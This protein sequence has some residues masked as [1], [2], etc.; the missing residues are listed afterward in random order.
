[1]VDASQSELNFVLS[2]VRPL[3]LSELPSGQSVIITFALSVSLTNFNALQVFQEAAEHLP[4]LHPRDR[5][6]VQPVWLP[7][8]AGLLQ[9]DSL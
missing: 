8:S 2:I 3:N 5:L 6:H 7:R 9:V 1:M 4:G